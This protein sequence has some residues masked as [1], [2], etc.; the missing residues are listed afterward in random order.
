MKYLLPTARSAENIQ[1]I[2]NLPE[3]TIIITN[4]PEFPE[5]GYECIYSAADGYWRALNQAISEISWS[6]PFV[7]LADDINPEGWWAEVAMEEYAKKFPFGLGL[8]VLNDLNV[9]QGGA[10]F[11]VITKAWLY[12]L[13][14]VPRFPDEFAHNF[15]DTIVANCS[16]DLGR[17]YFCEKAVVE[18]LH[19]VVGKAEDDAVYKENRR[20]SKENGDK[21]IKDQF[22][23]MWIYGGRKEAKKRFMDTLSK[24]AY[25][26]IGPE[27]SGTHMMR[28][29]LVSAGCHWEQ[30][31]EEVDEDKLNF[32]G[33]AQKLVI[34]RSMPHAHKWPKL[35]KIHKLLEEAGYRVFVIFTIRDF[36]ASAI[37]V[38]NRGYGKKV[39]DCY[40]NQFSLLIQLG[41]YLDL[42]VDPERF[43]YSTYEAFVGSVGFRKWL[44][45]RLGLEMPEIE[46]Y[47][48]N[49]KY[50]S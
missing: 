29:A 30:W 43:V 26:V 46:V 41:E 7:W 22:D 49:T 36:N 47:D 13:F 14:G 19:P 3:E 39:E 8:L 4:N 45:E 21:K 31:Y 35:A 37:S 16:K 5:I 6:E 9:R 17:Y 20:R 1:N 33:P 27:G 38:I 28:N 34:R 23:Q 40:I 18:H 42:C 10:A 11:G 25:F 32:D 15:L 2:P 44:F 12:V 48:G 24:T 50:Y